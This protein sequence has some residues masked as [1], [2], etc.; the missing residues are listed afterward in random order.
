[1]RRALTSQP[2]WFQLFHPIGGVRARPLSSSGG[3]P[4]WTGA[5]PD[6][7]SRTGSTA[8]RGRTRVRWAGRIAGSLERRPFGSAVTPRRDRRAGAGPPPPRAGGGRVG[9]G[10]GASRALG[11]GGR[12]G[13]R[14][15]RGGIGEPG[16]LRRRGE[17]EG[18]RIHAVA[19]TGRRRAVLEDVAQ[20]DRKS[21]RLN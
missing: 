20:V 4:E 16:Q 11:R 15:P 6:D 2:K 7:Q 10:A 8:S 5:A 1:M 19:Q 14:S 12:G 3:R 17:R 9:G 13:A 18:L 21:T